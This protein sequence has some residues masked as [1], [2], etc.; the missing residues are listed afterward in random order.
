MF[1]H[2][3][4]GRAYSVAEWHADAMHAVQKAWR[5][6]RLP[7]LAGGTGL[8]FRAILEGLAPVPDIPD[9]IR[10]SV[11]HLRE[12]SGAEALLTR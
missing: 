3:D 8:Y 1:G 7:I 10:I 9:D 11:R 2:V 6:G 5:E 4:A 12:K